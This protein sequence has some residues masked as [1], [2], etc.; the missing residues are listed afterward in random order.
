MK[1]LAVAMLAI[2]SASCAL[3]P[4]HTQMQ[5]DASI[6]NPESLKNLA[7]FPKAPDGFQRYV[8]HLNPNVQDEAYQV[9]LIVGKTVTVDCNQH[10]LGGSIAEKNLQGWGYTYYEF[11]T[12]GMMA[13]TKM[14]CPNQAETEKFISGATKLV[15]YNSRLPIVFFVPHG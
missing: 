11:A 5:E 6:V 7:P 2:L 12:Q 15:R 4:H 13:S 3:N 9:E 14:A 10:R 8:I 1:F